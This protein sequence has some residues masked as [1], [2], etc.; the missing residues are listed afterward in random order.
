[1][2]EFEDQHLGSAVRSHWLPKT[3]CKV[4]Y[5]NVS[6]ALQSVCS[7]A[8]LFLLDREKN[9]L[10][11]EVW[12]HFSQETSEVQNLQNLQMNTLQLL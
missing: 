4:R 7:A 5:M 8:T 1:M 3:V 6:T 2:R 12:Q 10:L 9:T 11:F